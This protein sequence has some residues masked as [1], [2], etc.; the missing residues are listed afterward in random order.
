MSSTNGPSMRHVDF[1]LHG[2]AGIRLVDPSPRDVEAVTRQLGPIQAPLSGP[3]DIVVRFVDRLA[4][5]TMR[6]LGIDEVGF[7]EDAFLVLRS[8]HG[9]RAK[10]QFDFMQIGQQ[11][12][13]I[14][15]S[16]L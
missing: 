1:D 9:T 7:T 4:T 10:V 3:P 11:C 15:E 13:I 16:G 14:C 12:E 2:L 8:K 6:Y 5:P